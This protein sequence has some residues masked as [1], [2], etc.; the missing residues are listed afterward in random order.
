[1]AEAVAGVYASEWSRIVAT[2]IRYTGDWDLAEECAQDAFAQALERWPRDGVP[3]RPGAWL[4]TTARNRA[5]DRLRRTA[6]E[7]TKLREMAR[8]TNPDEVPP[9]DLPD[10]GVPDDRLELIF[11]CCHPALPIEARVALTLRSLAGLST[12]EIARAFLVPEKTMAQRLVRAKNKIRNAAIPFRVPPD[13]LLPERTSAVLAVLYLLFNEGYSASAGAE[14]VRR[15]LTAEAI[16]LARVLAALMPDEPEAQA[17]LALM[18]LHDAR[19]AG[20]L[21]AS[22][23]VVP[24]DEQDRTRWDRAQIDEATGILDRALRRRRTGPYQ[25]QAAIA[26]CHATAAD[27]A[28]TDWTEIALLYRELANLTPGPVVELNR[29]V[30][31]AMA[32][33]P[34]A[35]LPLLDALAA[36]GALA[37]YHLLPATRAD[38][39]RRLD[40]RAEAAGAYREALALT[41]TDAE[42]RYLERRL[43]EVTPDEP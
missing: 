40:R 3:E 20:R 29:A 36:S 30:A 24:L 12:G 41:R 5:L 43:A 11:T 23:E 16:R 7:A 22:G 39:L 25:L 33:G 35:A 17:L 15:N 13:H 4:T 6:V 32:D 26:A 14:L 31:V 37:G 21:D 42:R 27:A 9:F 1:M 28:E 38:L 2:L 18:L 8:M 34:A 10:G 19:R